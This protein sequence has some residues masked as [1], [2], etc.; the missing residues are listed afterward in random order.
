MFQFCFES[1][2]DL[3]TILDKA[4]FHFKRWMLILQRW[5]PIISDS[6]PARIP[7]WITVH[8]IPLHYWKDDTIEAIGTALGPIEVR[9]PTKAQLR[10][11]INGL[12][13]LIMKMDLQLP[14]KDVVEVE[15]DYEKLDKH[16]FLCKSLSHEKD[17]CPLKQEGGY[18]DIEKTELGISQ[19]NTL[20]R[21]AD[22]RKRQEDRRSARVAATSHRQQGAR[23]TNARSNYYR[24]ISLLQ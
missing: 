21:I 1:E 14:S 7:F 8:G 16:C 9:E 12:E 15:L 11:Q 6:F 23:W 10:V 22:G 17:D 20:E 3:Q 4:P 5:E 19:R 18:K 13:P 24:P 2:K